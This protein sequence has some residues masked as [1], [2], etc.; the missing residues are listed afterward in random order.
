MRIQITLYS[1][2]GKYRPISTVVSV[3]SIEWAKAHKKELQE[4]G[5]AK[6]CAERKTDIWALQRDGF[7]LIK[8][9]VYQPTT[10]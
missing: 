4:R 6:I 10:D 9:R 1:K 2:T 5:V 7:T 8:M 3:E